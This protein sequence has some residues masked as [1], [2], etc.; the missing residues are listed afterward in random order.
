M[1]T[2]QIQRLAR[3]GERLYRVKLKKLLE[4]QYK[5]QY[6]AI[7][8][9]SREYFVGRTVVEALQKAEDRY[10]NKQFHLIKIGYPAAISFKHPVAL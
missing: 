6:V 5:G 3:R 4:P 1:S 2:V 9:D 10:P 7:E 8:V